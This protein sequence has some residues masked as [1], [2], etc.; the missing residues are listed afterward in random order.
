MEA[1][2]SIELG[3]AAPALE[4]PWNDPD[5]HL[6]YFDLRRQPDLIADI[7]EAQQFPAL[8]RFLTEANSPLSA[9]QTAKCDVWT[10]ETE[11]AE[12]LYDAGFEQSCY[13]D[14]VLAEQVAPLRE[15]LEVH[16][17]AA[18]EMAHVLGENEVLEAFAEIMVRRC[19]FHCSA[20]A[21]E[22]VAGYCLTLFLTGY[23]ATP[24]KTALCWDRAIEF[25]AGCVLRVQPHEGRAQPR[26]LS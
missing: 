13:V 17:L 23:G 14:L 15:C 7:P 16:Q 25:A 2:Y 4:I 20:D 21:D 24:A 12:N 10:D 8:R 11:A 9:W 1:D 3:P 19:Y 22:S 18:K 5:E 6:H 26:E